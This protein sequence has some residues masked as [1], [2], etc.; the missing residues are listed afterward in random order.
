MAALKNY[1]ADLTA[2][3]K[4]NLNISLVVALTLLIAA[5][6]FS[7]QIHKQRLITDSPPDTIRVEMPPTSQT[8]KPP[9]PPKPPQIIM[10]T[11]D[12]VFEDIELNDVEIDR[13]AQFDA[14]P[15]LEPPR[16]DIPN[17]P[18]YDYPEILPEPIDGMKALQEKV[19]YPEIARRAGIEGIVFIEAK[20]DKEGN[21]VE[22]VVKKGVWDGLDESAL[23]A[24]L[25][26]K[27]HPGKQRGK[28]VNVKMVIP[29]KFV[30]R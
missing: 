24:V 11:L 14:P 19:Y 13:D 26:T 17:E 27:F 6:K 22:A 1:S 25:Q 5:F 18:F 8:S 28:P 2:K 30:L 15:P 12:D 9:L 4:R 7:P 29:I 10:A 16:T 20:I 21:V 3:Y 23:N